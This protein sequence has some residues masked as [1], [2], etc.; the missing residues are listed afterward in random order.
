MGS[1]TPATQRP[2]DRVPAGIT[3]R[4][5]VPATS[6]NLGPGFDAAGLAV[7]LF[8][9]VEII[10]T[11]AGYCVEITGYGQD[12]LPTDSRHLIISTIRELLA[13][14]GWTVPGLKVRAI[15]RIPHSRGLGSS[16][17]A[18]VAAVL[19][20]QGLLP[21]HAQR[22]HDELLQWAAELEG[23]PDNVA[24]ALFGGLTL[25][26]STHAQ[27]HTARFE[28]APELTP[29]VAIP[30]KPVATATAR[31]L[32]PE[33]VPHA[34]A[35]ANAASAALLAPAITTD[36]SLLYVATRDYL[37][38]EYRF[39]AMPHTLNVVR[40]MRAH[41]F[42]AVVSGAGPTVMVLTACPE[43]ARRAYAALEETVAPQRR[44]WDLHILAV[45]LEGAKLEIVRP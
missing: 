25:S 27:F 42:A 5:S 41:G 45:N 24:P 34:E 20:A 21:R 19:G 37:H 38:Q 2:P 36:P 26:W 43:E 32:L 3:V 17:A 12:Y 31:E 10:S 15:N 7:Q 22:T 29:V 4:V 9:E 44:H 33:A 6:A 28:P 13:S 18:H 14:I 23:H 1:A 16:A 39:A 11:E 40:V 8:D 35:A 30:D